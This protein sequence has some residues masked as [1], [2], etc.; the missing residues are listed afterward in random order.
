M[1]D[2]WQRLEIVSPDIPV[3]PIEKLIATTRLVL[4]VILKAAQ[5]ALAAARLINDPIAATLEALIKEIEDTLKSLLDGAGGYMLHVPIQKRIVHTFHGQGDL[6]PDW[7]IPKVPVLTGVL[8]NPAY[9][10]NSSRLFSDAPTQNNDPETIARIAASNRYS[11]G[12][13]GFV[14]AV[15]N[16]L[17]DAGDFNRPQFNSERDYV[18]GF[19][20][21]LGTN[22]NILDLIEDLMRFRIFFNSPNYVKWPKPLNLRAIAMG[23]VTRGTALF[24]D[25]S[26]QSGSCRVTL[27]WDP[28]KFPI[29]SLTD[30]GGAS[31]RPVR[32]AV[33]RGKNSLR[34]STARSVSELF[35][36]GG[37]ILTKGKKSTM[38]DIEVIHEGK[39]NVTK[40]SYEDYIASDVEESDVYYYA[41][42]WQLQGFGPDDDVNALVKQAEDA[43]DGEYSGVP[44]IMPY[45]DISN[46]ARVTMGVTVPSSH[47]P[48]WYRTGSLREMAPPV[49]RVLED[50]MALM[51][52]FA[53]RIA[54]SSKA[55]EELLVFIEDEINKYV[56]IG[57]RVVS[58]VERLLYLLQPPKA[59]IYTH[60]FYGMGGNNYFLNDLCVNMLDPNVPKAPPFHRG[61]E[62]VTGL[63]FLAGGRSP[64]VKKVVESVGWLFGL[65]KDSFQSFSDVV[66]K[67]DFG[68]IW[69]DKDMNSGVLVY[70]PQTPPGYTDP[71]LP[72]SDWL[73][74][75]MATIEIPSVSQV[76]GDNMGTTDTP[77]KDVNF[78][79]DMCP[80][81]SDSTMD[82]CAP[83][84]KTDMALKVIDGAMAINFKDNLSV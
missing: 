76:I 12:N 36:D 80:L 26:G 65:S 48:D 31:F 13:A 59:G 73:D 6:T 64:D 29:T 68:D 43:R 81:C 34:M 5:I 14:N 8:K 49:A 38:G 1:A 60:G 16:S 57:N 21:V 79:P 15:I 24:T 18:A 44:G 62:Y 41:V 72:N 25:K 56:G 61:D 75:L 10:D 17:Y 7:G 2:K 58:E 20:V 70:P 67:E 54:G 33:I 50:I 84:S 83:V 63:V 11:G 53:S 78:T 82:I 52:L 42:A 9:G 40:I 4:D 51:A 74:T 27:T 69:K 55:L 39:Y 45:Q 47:R 35:S 28:P 22:L 46:V 71:D 3:E 19:V 32:Y 66:S 77:E 37:E 23:K 30:L